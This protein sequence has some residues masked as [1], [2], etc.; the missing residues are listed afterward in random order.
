[1]IHFNLRYVTGFL[2]F[3]AVFSACTNY[4]KAYQKN[5]DFP[6]L[7]SS[8]FDHFDAHT[9]KMF[10]MLTGTSTGITFVNSMKFSFLD[11]NNSYVNYY[12]GGGVGVLNANGDSLPD[13][14]FTG[15]LVH[16]ALYIN[17]GNMHFKDVTA[18]AGIPLK[19]KGW[20]TGVAIADVN[21]DGLDDIYVLHSK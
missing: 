8:K 11:D 19:N 20:S 4:E 5:Y 16:D 3:A 7:D 15:N 12:N 2:F 18:Q 13:L 21:N 9:N 14:Y 10:D 17:E 6:P 1:M